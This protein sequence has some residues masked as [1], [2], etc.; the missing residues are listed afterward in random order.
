MTMHGLANVKFNQYVGF[1]TLHLFPRE[2]KRVHPFPKDWTVVQL[3][4]N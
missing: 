3:M 4:L 2:L 1:E